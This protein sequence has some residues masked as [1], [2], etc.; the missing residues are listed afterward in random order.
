MNRTL[1]L[2]GLV[3]GLALPL[4]GCAVTVR[5]GETAASVQGQ[6]V[7][8]WGH[9]GMRFEFPGLVVIDRGS[10]PHHFYAVFQSDASLYDVYLDVDRRM[11]E[12]GWFR[13]SFDESFDTIH[14]IYTRGRDRAYVVIRQESPG[15]RYRLTIDD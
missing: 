13:R 1:R 10:R 7:I 5:P 2:A 4:A 14:A 9:L 3:A 8:V 12:H 11:F 6:G 15:A